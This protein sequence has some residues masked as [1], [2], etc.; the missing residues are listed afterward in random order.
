M[1]YHN[2]NEFK[3]YF[4]CLSDGL[5]K[6]KI[7][8]YVRLSKED[9]KSI[10]LSIDNQIKS[11]ARYLRNFEDFEIID[12]YIDDGMTGTDFD[13]ADYMR[14]K[15]DVESGIV[16]CI[17]VKDLTRY[18]RNLADAIKELDNYVLVHKLRFISIR[19]PEVDTYKNPRQISS[20]EVYQALQNAEDHARI[21]SIKVRDIKEQKREDGEK[22]GGFPPYGY[23]PNPDGEHWLYDP[24]AGETVKK[25]FSWSAEG[26]S[27]RAIAKKLNALSIPNPTAYKHSIGLNYYNPNAKNNS[28]LWWSSTIRRILLDKNYIGYSVQGK[29]SSFDHK[30]HKQI[31]NKK[32]DYVEVA[33]CHEKA[34]TDEIFQKVSKLKAQRTR[35]TKT[36]E[37]HLFAN[38]T[39]CP[40]CERIMRKTSAKG[41]SYLVCRT[42]RDLGKE[43]CA[44]K[45][46]INL[47][48]LENIILKVIQAQI[49]LVIDLNSIIEKIN[50]KPEVKNDT[51]RLKQRLEEIKHEIEKT[52][53][54]F[55][56]SYYDWKN[57]EISKEQYQRIRKRTEEKIEQLNNSFRSL[58]TQKQHV[59]KGIKSNDEYFSTFLKYRNVEKLDRFM[60]TELIHRIYVNEDKSIKVEFNFQD[61]YLLI[62]DYIKQNQDEKEISK[63]LKKTLNRSEKNKKVEK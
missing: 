15:G 20:S 63:E 47:E 35:S 41:K 23:L 13:R 10:S 60:V 45:N 38:L 7:A 29:S 34:V 12:I 44:T 31:P 36:G 53:R 4:N 26:L 54:I 50:Q 49:N 33:N 55:D 5:R 61:Q 58:A 51:V 30:R 19:I 1:E 52:E 62:L 9:G 2:L 59:E 56:S 17:I 18:S 14:L 21:T 46:S 8:I 57:E 40:N 42:Y 39:Y 27:D 24:I 37:V 43:Y 32:E 25:I 28:G 6:W 3:D 48:T 22:N 11:I 16:N